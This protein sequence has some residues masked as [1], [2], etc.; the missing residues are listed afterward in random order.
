VVVVRATLR[1]M[2]EAIDHERGIG[3]YSVTNVR[4]VNRAMHFTFMNMLWVLIDMP[5]ESDFLVVY[6]NFK[7]VDGLS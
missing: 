3:M 5:A 6:P 2:S 1:Q 4:R 7:V